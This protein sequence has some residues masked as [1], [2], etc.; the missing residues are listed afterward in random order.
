MSITEQRI[1]NTI[2]IRVLV[3][4]TVLHEGLAGEHGLSIFIETNKG[5]VLWDTGQSEIFMENADSLGVSFENVRAIALSHGHYDHTGGINA[6]FDRIND[7]VLYA[8]PG[9]FQERFTPSS[10]M[11]KPPRSIGI[12]FKRETIERMSGNTVLSTKPTEILPGVFTTGEIPRLTGYE[13]TGGDFYL[14]AAL[15]TP[16]PLIDDQSLVIETGDGL[17]LILGCCHAGLINTMTFIAER[18]GT[19]KFLLV[20]GGMHLIN[21]DKDRI[22]KTIRALEKFSVDTFAP[23]HCTGKQALNAFTKMFPDRT[24]PLYTGWEWKLD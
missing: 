6:A 11:R 5:D 21:A 2:F 17:I 13:D 14:D 8:H 12:Q 20:A 3:D 10:E 18:W 24:S 4:N 22:E 15:T 1:T 16:D 9:I 19:E 23:G 7:A